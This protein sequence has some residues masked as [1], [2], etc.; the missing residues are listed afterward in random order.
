ML[1]HVRCDIR[2]GA[3]GE[4]VLLLQEVQSDWAQRARRA[5]STG[6]MKSADEQPPPFFKEWPALA[7]KLIFLHAA[8][9]GV[10]AVAWTRGTH[11]VVRYNG[12][13][14]AGLIELYDR[15]LPRQVNRMLKSIG[16]RRSE[17]RRVGKECSS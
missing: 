8:C 13:G 16:I 17:E 14:A 2:E 15:T 5:V 9:L 3:D 10:D 1:A 6:E 11:Q 4:Q 7:M 12:L